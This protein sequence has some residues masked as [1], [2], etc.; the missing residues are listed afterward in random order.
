MEGIKWSFFEKKNFAQ[1]KSVWGENSFDQL[2]RI[3]DM[4]E[5]K[6]SKEIKYVTRTFL[7]CFGALFY[8]ERNIS[9]EIELRRLKGKVLL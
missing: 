9:S 7:A 4:C 6:H 3:S 1:R 2:Q 8:H 5:W